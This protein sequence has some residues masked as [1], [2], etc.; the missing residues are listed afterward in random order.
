MEKPISVDKIELI[1]IALAAYQPD[2]EPFAQQLSSIQSQSYP[3]WVCVIRF[4][5][6]LDETLSQPQIRPF[7]AD[8]RFVWRENS[9]RLGHKKNFE[10]AIQ[11]CVELLVDW[12]ACSDQDDIWYPNKLELCLK[13]LKLRPKLS[14]VHS[15]MHVLR[16]TQIE[17][18]TAWVTE[19][20]GVHN[21]KPR[22]FFVRNIVAGCSMLFDA[23]LARKF[24]NI[25]DGVEYH[26]WW[27]AL[28]ASYHGGVYSI[29]QPLYA[30]RQHALNEVGITPF[31]TISQATRKL[32]WMEILEKCKKTWQR[33]WSIGRA[34]LKE[35]LPM[36][37]IERV[38]FY[39][40]ADFGLGFFIL[41]LVSWRSDPA[42]T[43]A[44]IARSIGKFLCVFVWNKDGRGSRI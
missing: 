44:C 20:R 35:K 5:S 1:G 21:S 30:Y 13:E 39:S 41:A 18:Q 29:S 27:Y 26:D 7:L 24:P 42:Y 23:E 9:T 4:D 2:L 16:G 6:P 8:S 38:T 10:R 25:P 40:G 3:H 17:S 19:K 32:S 43:K 14:L 28:V 37:W 31:Q 36:S 22:H 15:D 33:T 12:I 34:A 11:D